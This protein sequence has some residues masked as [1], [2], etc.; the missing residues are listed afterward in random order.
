MAKETVEARKRRRHENLT[1]YLYIGPAAIILAVFSIFPVCYAVYVSLFNWRLRQGE[2]VGL[3]NYVRALTADPKFGQSLVSTV[4]YVVGTVPVSIGLGLLI[5]NLL[6]QKIRGRAVYRTIYFLPYI[7]SVVAAAAVWLWIL[8]PAPNDWG[9][10]NA[11]MKKVGLPAQG[12]VE[13]ET[14]V[15]QL[16][17]QHF[18]GSLPDWM[19]G[20]S[21]ALV[22]VMAFSVWQSLGFDVVVLLAALT[23]VPKEI[24]EAAAIDGATGWQRLRYVTVPLISPTLYFL[25]IVSVIRAFRVFN[26]VYIL[27]SKE[28]SGSANTVTVYIFNAFYGEGGQ[29]VRVGYGSALAMILFV[30]ILLVTL[31]QMRVIGTRVHY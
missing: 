23:N 12:W 20:P 2:F 15:F 28:A 22:C 5:A 6:A 11:V 17:A 21:L 1:G 16:V 13:E 29:S 4:W 26:H 10:A 31:V 14:G 7:T 25:S 18:G 27:A 9:L 19:G 24:Y 8:Y 3:D 30:I